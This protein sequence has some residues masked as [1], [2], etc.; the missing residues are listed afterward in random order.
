[1]KC[2]ICGKDVE[3]K[4]RQVGTDEN[5]EPVFNEYAICRDCKK[6]WNLDKQRAKKA[7]AKQAVSPA[8]ESDGK[9]EKTKSE[10]AA[11]E[12]KAAV[13]KPAANREELTKKVSSEEASAAKSSA[14]K[15]AAAAKA[16]SDKDVSGKDA[17][18]KRPAPRKKAAG[19]QSEK[20]A[21]D[22]SASETGTRKPAADKTK[23][24]PR[25]KSSGGTRP[26]KS[27][28][29]ASSASV[30]SRPARKRLEEASVS[31]DGEENRLGNIPSEKVRAKREKAVRKGYNDMLS[32]DPKHKASAK[33]S[34]PDI[35]DEEETEKSASAK[36]RD[37]E[38]V[39]RKTPEPEID[40]F[41]DDDDYE[42]TVSRFRPAR[43]VMGVIS[44]IGFGFFIYKGF[45]EGLQGVSSGSDSSGTTFIILALCFLV[46]AMLYFIMQRKKTVFAFLLPMLFYVGSAVAA[47]LMK[48]NDTILLASAAAAGVLAVIS[49]ILAIASRGGSDYDDYDDPFADES[50]D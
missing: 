3:L 26:V 36:R 13:K 34:S 25:K 42:E 14:A 48:G 30:K 5:G 41:Y 32:T 49:L 28:E 11:A 15:K 37:A 2:P 16:V 29:G 1:M 8:A 46:S 40:D 43:I 39:S 17:A 19:S 44:L 38:K 7:A 21:A 12:E 6:Q 33:K 23:T 24:A 35:S 27:G 31:E 50:D 10:A 22:G 4:N 45:I 18:A 20:A 9:A 47:F